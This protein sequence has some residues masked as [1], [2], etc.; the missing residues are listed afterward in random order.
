MDGILCVFI[1]AGSQK[2]SN[3]DAFYCVTNKKCS[4]DPFCCV[5]YNYTAAKHLLLPEI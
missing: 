3:G 2:C 1:K 4:G 5:R